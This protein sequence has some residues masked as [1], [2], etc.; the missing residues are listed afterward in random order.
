MRALEITMT[1]TQQETPIASF[2]SEIIGGVIIFALFQIASY[3]LSFVADGLSGAIGHVFVTA[4]SWSAAL[5]GWL[6][7]GFLLL[8]VVGAFVNLSKNLRAR[9]G[10]RL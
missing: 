1:T 2:A 10:G 9:R 6:A 8:V 3:G 7:W 5:T 4:L